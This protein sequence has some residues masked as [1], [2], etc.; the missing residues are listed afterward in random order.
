MI[1]NSSFK[2]IYIVKDLDFTAETFVGTLEVISD[3]PTGEA[4]L[5]RVNIAF[6]TVNL[7]KILI[8]GIIVLGVS[9]FLFTRLR[10]KR[11][12]RTS[13]RKGFLNIN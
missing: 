1:T 10:K 2:A 7:R 8:P 11:K 5:R 4:E 13:K 12:S 3:A 6:R 9:I